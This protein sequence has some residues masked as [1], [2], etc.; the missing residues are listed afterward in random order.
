MLATYPKELKAGS[1]RDPGS[2]QHY[3]SQQV[4][5]TQVHISGRMHKQNVAHVCE[6]KLFRLK[7]EGYSD[8]SYNTKES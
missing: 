7:K 6:G 3:N 8:T 5:T 1:Q 4:E 2:Q